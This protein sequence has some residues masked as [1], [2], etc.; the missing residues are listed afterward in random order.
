MIVGPGFY[1]PVIVVIK[2][3]I[4]FGAAKLCR[5]KSCAE[6]DAFYGRYAEEDRCQ[7]AFQAI[8]H[9]S[10]DASGQSCRT[11][12]YDAAHGI[13]VVFGLQNGLRHFFAGCFGQNGKLHFLQFHQGFC[14]DADRIQR[15]IFDACNGVKMCSDF[16]V[17]FF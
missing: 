14:A 3:I 4:V 12:F 13:Q 10:A 16:D 8:V 9:S 6:F 15:G 7:I 1:L 17:F 11:H 2:R 5:V